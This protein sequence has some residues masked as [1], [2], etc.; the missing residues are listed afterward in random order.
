M[1]LESIYSF[2]TNGFYWIPLRFKESRVKALGH[3][4]RDVWRHSYFTDLSTL[5]PH[6]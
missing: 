3:V 5:P 1:C 2:N 6:I 4:M